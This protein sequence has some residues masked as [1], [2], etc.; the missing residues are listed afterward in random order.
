HRA[1]GAARLEAARML[2]QLELEEHLR[3]AAGR[4][5][6]GIA[7][8]PPE[9]R[10]GDPVAEPCAS[11]ADVLERRPSVVHGPILSR[12][13]VGGHGTRP[14]RADRGA[15]H[16]AA[17]DPAAAADARCLLPGLRAVQA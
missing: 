16:P 17:A 5:L 12:A 7:A 13:Y 1:E 11:G 4:V 15:A 9:R 8:P 3:R 10:L 2:E 14:R 6:D